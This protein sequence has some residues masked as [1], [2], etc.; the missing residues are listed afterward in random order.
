MYTYLRFLFTANILLDGKSYNV[1]NLSNWNKYDIENISS[2]LSNFD[3]L[4]TTNYDMLLESI[5]K[6]K[7]SHLHGYYSKQKKRVLSQS[8]GIFYNMVRYDLSTAVIG[9]FFLSKSFLPITSKQAAKQPQ[10]SNIEI[11]DQ[12]LERVIKETQ[13]QIIVIFGLNMD[14]DFHILRDIQ[15]FFEAGKI[16]SPHI[17]YCYF[18]EDDKN[19][20]INGYD[21]CITYSEELCDFVRNTIKVSIIDSKQ[22]IEKLFSF[23]E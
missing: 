14:N 1:T 10:N 6:R 7:I 8:L 15:I 18:N 22:L 20:F 23:T 5:T 16:K 17:I 11:Y 2:F 19:G 3:S 13:S 4:M 9:D 21:A 12:I